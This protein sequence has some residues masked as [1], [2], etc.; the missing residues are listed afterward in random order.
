M[1]LDAF[2]VCGMRHRIILMECKEYNDFLVLTL[3]VLLKSYTEFTLATIMGGNHQ[4]SLQG[5]K[6]IFDAVHDF[7]TVSRQFCNEFIVDN[8]IG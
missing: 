8:L 7:I 5:N 1:I 2:V 6:V 4:L 3:K